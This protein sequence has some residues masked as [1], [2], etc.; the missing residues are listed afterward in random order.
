MAQPGHAAMSRFSL[1]SEVK[2]K[3]HDCDR[4]L[5]DPKTDS[6]DVRSLVASLIPG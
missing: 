6:R 2:R 5:L 1:L 4:R 3:S